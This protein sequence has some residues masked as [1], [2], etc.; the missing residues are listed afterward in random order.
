MLTLRIDW[1]LAK[2]GARSDARAFF[3]IYQEINFQFLNK[4]GLAS[5]LAKKTWLMTMGAV[6][7]VD[8]VDPL[9]PLRPV[10]WVR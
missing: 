1:G 6:G 8:S 9:N 7:A 4:K 2:F 5:D 10:H 3:A